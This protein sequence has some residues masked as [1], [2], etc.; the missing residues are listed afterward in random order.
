MSGRD[1]GVLA[2]RERVAAVHVHAEPVPV[3]GEVERRRL[4]RADR[5]RVHERE[6]GHVEEVVDHE[7]RADVGGDRIERAVHEGGVVGLGHVE[8]LG[9]RRLR[10]EEHHAVL[11]RDRGGDGRDRA[12][13]DVLRGAERGDLA[14][15]TG[16]VE[17][18][19]VVTAAEERAVDGARRRAAR[20]GAGTGRRTR[21]ASAAAASRV[22]EAD[23]HPVV[24][25]QAHRDAVSR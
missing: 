22:G 21:R 3:D 24:A 25:E 14:A 10:R 20:A 15:R 6:V 11:F 23:E 17:A 4:R 9:Q 8:Q 7:A 13:R 5:R 18:P 19:A 2:V 12:R 1:A 16:G